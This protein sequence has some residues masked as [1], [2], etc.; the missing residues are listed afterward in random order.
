M[1]A[2]DR[3]KR[4]ERIR[5]QREQLRARMNS[6]LGQERAEEN[7]KA[8]RKAKLLGELLLGEAAQNEKTKSWITQFLDKRLTAMGE[9][10]LFDLPATVQKPEGPSS[11]SNPQSAAH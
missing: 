10:A 6:L 11:G 2:S 9:R 3:N 5:A 4:I 8:A 7:K 1:D